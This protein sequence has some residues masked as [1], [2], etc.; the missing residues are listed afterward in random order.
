MN[1]RALTMAVA[2]AMM[3][4]LGVSVPS[5]AGT[6]ISTVLSVNDSGGAADEFVATFTGTGGSISDVHTL[7]A[8]TTS[9]EGTVS[10]IGTTSTIIDG[11]TGVQID[12]GS[13]LPNGPG[14]LVFEFLTSSGS[15]GIGSIDWKL[16]IGS[17]PPG[18]GYIV[19][20]AVVPEP[21]SMG[22]LGI[23]MIGYLSWRRLRGRKPVAV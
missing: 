23:G 19:T 6:Y 20:T 8:G 3:G 16:T 13:P 9:T 2:M 17:D 7:L 18:S 12:F 4:T 1:K 14:I 15:V 10:S 5:E 22:L 21:G 11:G